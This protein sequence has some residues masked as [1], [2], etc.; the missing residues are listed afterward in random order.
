MNPIIT[1]LARYKYARY[2]VFTL[3]GVIIGLWLGNQYP[4]A[5]AQLWALPA[6]SLA[7]ALAGIVGGQAATAGWKARVDEALNTPPPGATI[8]QAE[9]GEVVPK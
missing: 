1:I 9:K 5:N 3:A 4:T 6:V 2:T 7:M 8:C